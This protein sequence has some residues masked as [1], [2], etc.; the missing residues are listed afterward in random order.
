MSFT[1]ANTLYTIGHS[2]H[3]LERFLELLQ[4]HAIT[5]IVDVRTMPQSRFAPQFNQKNFIE[6]LTQIGCRYVFLGK[7]LG[8]KRQEESSLFQEGCERLLQEVADNRVA[9]LCS[10]KDP[11][12][13]HRAYWISRALCNRLP[14]Q[15]ILADG[16]T[17]SH[18]ELEGL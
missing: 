6:S 4:M 7:E 2:N 18:E 9:I 11:A 14:I 1:T 12:K 16:S 17:I 3:S 10:E 13:C 5:T 8:G 15:H